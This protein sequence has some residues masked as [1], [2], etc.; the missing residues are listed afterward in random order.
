MSPYVKE[1]R[2]KEFSKRWAGTRFGS[3]VVVKFHKDLGREKEYSCLCACGESCVVRL[4][5]LRH[6]GTDRCPECMRL[7]V[8]RAR[9]II[10]TRD[11]RS[12][13]FRRPLVHGECSTSLYKSWC[14]MK[15]RCTNTPHKCYE[16]IGYTTA[17]Q[18]YEQFKEDMGHTHFEGACLDRINPTI[19]YSKDNCQWL[20]K[21]DHAIKTRVDS[22]Y[23]KETL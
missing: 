6:K 19:G 1:Q 14:G 8:S 7:K 18:H 21:S 12:G 3:L 11:S 17:W 20:T 4:S 9:S 15:S 16:G 13:V 2:I 22:V 10:A 23:F 5:N